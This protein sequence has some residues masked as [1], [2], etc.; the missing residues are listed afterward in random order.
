MSSNPKINRNTRTTSITKFGTGNTTIVAG[1]ADQDQWSDSDS[2][3]NI[4]TKGINVHHI[5]DVDTTSS[6][7]NHTAFKPMLGPGN[8]VVDQYDIV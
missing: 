8:G 5:F 7:S 4:A 3:T 2:N 6:V 1:R